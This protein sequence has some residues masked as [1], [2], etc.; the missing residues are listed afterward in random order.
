MPTA[1]LTHAATTKLQLMNLKSAAQGLGL[2]ASSIGWAVLESLVGIT[3]QGSGMVRNEE[4][5]REW[6]EIW[7]ALSV[8]KA[9]LFLPTSPL[10][11]LGSTG[12]AVFR[13][14]SHRLR[15]GKNSTLTITS[16]LYTQSKSFRD[17][18]NPN[19]VK[20]S[21][22]FTSLLLDTAKE[23]TSSSYPT[24]TLPSQT[25]T[26]SLPP[27]GTFTSISDLTKKPPLP[28]RPS[29]SSVN[30]SNLSTG[31]LSVSSSAS[32]A[33]PGTPSSTGGGGGGGRIHDFVGDYWYWWNQCCQ[34]DATN[35]NNNNNNN[36]WR[37]IVEEI[38][39]SIESSGGG[40]G[41]VGED[42]VSYLMNEIPFFVTSKDS[43]RRKGE[44]RRGEK[45][46]EKVLSH[47]QGKGRDKDVEGEDRD[48]EKERGYS[49]IYSINSYA[50]ISGYGPV[51]GGASGGGGGD[52]EGPAMDGVEDIEDLATRYQE[53]YVDL[54]EEVKR[55]V[56]EQLVQQEGVQEKDVDKEKDRDKKEEMEEKWSGQPAPEARRE[57]PDADSSSTTSATTTSTSYSET[58]INSSDTAH[59]EALSSRIAALTLIDF[60]LDDLDID[61]GGD[62]DGA[63]DAPASE[64]TSNEKEKSQNRLEREQAVLF[65]V[66]ECGESL[67]RFEEAKSPREKAAV[68]VVAHKI[69]VDGLTK[70]PP[71]RLKTEQEVQEKAAARAKSKDDVENV[72]TGLV[73]ATETDAA[74]SLAPTLFQ[75]HRKLHLLL[76][77]LSHCLL[78]LTVSVGGEV[79][80]SESE[81]TPKPP[82][83]DSSEGGEELLAT[84]KPPPESSAVDTEKQSKE[85]KEA[86][87]STLSLDTIF[88]LLILSIVKT[89]PPRLISHLLFTQRFRNRSFGGEEAYCLV[90]LM[91]VAE[92]VGALDPKAVLGTREGVLPG[93]ILAGDG[94]DELGAV[95]ERP[96]TPFGG[97]PIPIPID[98]TGGSAPGSR[99]SS[100]SYS[101]YSSSSRRD[102][103]AGDV[104]LSQSAASGTS[105]FSTSFTLRN[106]VEQ[107]VDAI[108]TSARGVLT[109]LSISGVMDSGIGVFKSLSQASLPGVSLN[110][111][112]LGIPGFGQQGG[113]RGRVV[114]PALNSTQAA[115]PWNGV[116][117]GGGK[118]VQG[119]GTG[120]EGA[121]TGTETIGEKGEKEREEVASP[122][123]MDDGPSRKETGFS[124]KSLKIPSVGL[125]IPGVG[126]SSNTPAKEEEMVS[127][128][129]PG[130][131]RSRKSLGS[132][133]G[134]ESDDEEEEDEDDSEG[135]EDEGDS[136]DDSEEG[137]GEEEESEY[138]KSDS[139]SIKSF[140][141]MMNSR[142]KSAKPKDTAKEGSGA[143]PA[144]PSLSDRLASVS[145]FG[146]RHKK[147]GSKRVLSPP[148]SR[149]SSLLVGNPSSQAFNRFD[150]P[151]SSRPQSPSPSIP[152]LSTLQLPPP[153]KRFL[154]ASS[155]NDLRMGEM[156]ELLKEYKRLAEAIRGAGGFD[157]ARDA[158]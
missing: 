53:F 78:A 13:E 74:S 35:N 129:R 108:S 110:G 153:N 85:S 18:S 82:V 7:S 134:G 139:R 12:H 112:T 95:G 125:N 69:L 142:K 151:V 62:E 5:E 104:P 32:I 33:R 92:F 84:A 22:G 107:Q 90:N 154:E 141:S 48:K 126:R 68:M 116:Y 157:A 91:A 59:D 146:S 93:M 66:R 75:T 64:Q 23:L 37:G 80:S 140:G 144:R 3:G 123:A 46:R 65:V 143:G 52:V 100:R 55:W 121:A 148:Q 133:Y 103:S 63:D 15:G 41:E 10:E 102:K 76:C 27:R 34:N 8:G 61:V 111:V 156:E 28:P 2:D 44:E 56:R 81:I 94:T 101:I 120:S 155:V 36:V 122:E 6:K 87:Q 16:T 83:I 98:R 145:S 21:S 31:S 130:S 19:P 42:E 57:H 89:N 79:T 40:G 99:R 135:E 38:E 60:S 71:V 131:V 49:W 128:S 67:S 158:T 51:V 150:T 86:S 136:E 106:R 72:V 138:Y 105:L 29:S 127:V 4:E 113:E 1:D 119:P 26:L 39:A 17:I 132:R 97:V 137:S 117:A 54:G 43:R 24:Y 14:K 9:S 70:L 73:T 147:T 47:V 109:G 149:R 25:S 96:P 30:A 45:E 77:R 58:G 11:S 88:P 115:A 118:A 20:R 124:I 152:S 114:T 50:H